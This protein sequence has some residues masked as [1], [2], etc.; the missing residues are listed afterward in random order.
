MMNPSAAIR[1]TNA[2]WAAAVHLLITPQQRAPGEPLRVA[3]LEWKEI[4]DFTSP[5][6][7]ASLGRTQA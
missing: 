6:P 3:T 7:T 1:A 5:D 4:Y 2:P